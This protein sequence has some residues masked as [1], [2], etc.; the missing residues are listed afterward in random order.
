[1]EPHKAV[2]PSPPSVVTAYPPLLPSPE[3]RVRLPPVLV[4]E[5]TAITEAAPPSLIEEL[6]AVILNV[7]LLPSPEPTGIATLPP[8][9]DTDDP[10]SRFKAALT[11]QPS[12][13]TAP[14]ILVPSPEAR[15]KLPPLLVDDDPAIIRAA[16]PSL[17]DES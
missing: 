9:P 3:V 14:L 13:V 8:K 16:P 2:L 6:P 1:M 7:P 4:G 17:I 15:V 5:D 11:S 12:I 10:L